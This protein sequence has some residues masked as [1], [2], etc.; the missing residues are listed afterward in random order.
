MNELEL[1]RQEVEACTKCDLYK[2]RTRVVFGDGNPNAKLLIVGE[3]PGYYED[4]RGLPFV[5]S[6]GKLLD[7]LLEEIGLNR[8][9]VYIANVIKCRPPNNRDPNI[10]EVSACSPYLFAQISY[11]SPRVIITMGNHSTRLLAETDLGMTK[12]HGRVFKKGDKV[13]LPTFHPA[14]CLY[15]PEWLKLSREDL[16]KIP[17]LLSKKDL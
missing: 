17:D 10:D 5:G 15:H 11:I 9:K 14:A 8:D 3:A 2:T 7:K 4:K 16:A 12:V 1:L 6:A 13:V